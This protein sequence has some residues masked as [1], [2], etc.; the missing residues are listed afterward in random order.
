MDGGNPWKCHV[1]YKRESYN[2][3]INTSPG[4]FPRMQGPSDEAPVQGARE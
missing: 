2:S 4:V 1:L 3:V